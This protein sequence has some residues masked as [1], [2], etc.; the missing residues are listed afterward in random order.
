MIAMPDAERKPRRV[1]STKGQLVEKKKLKLKE[2]PV[3]VES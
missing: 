3:R 1:E 2:I